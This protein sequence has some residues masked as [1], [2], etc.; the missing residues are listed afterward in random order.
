MI[1]I[2]F[3]MINAVSLPLDIAFTDQIRKIEFIGSLD[4]FTM[5]VFI[6]DMILGFFTSYINVQSGE[7]VFGYYFIGKNYIFN[8][9]FILDLLSTF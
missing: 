5:Y 1:I 7:E 2:F 3:A 6:V 8:G 4:N 9:T